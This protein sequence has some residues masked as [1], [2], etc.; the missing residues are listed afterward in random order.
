MNC[1]V[2]GH[3]A[4]TFKRYAFTKQGVSFLQNAQGFL[5]CQECGALLRVTH[6]TKAF[7]W[8]FGAALALLIAF[9]VFFRRLLDAY[10][11]STV[12]FTWLLL[13]ALYAV[14][15][16]YGLWR[17]AVVQKAGAGTTPPAA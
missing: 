3:E 11:A 13:I 5:T 16:G 6:F 8:M 2:C 9:A 17:F 7:W 1:P 12:T 15:F 4:S 10:G 14:L